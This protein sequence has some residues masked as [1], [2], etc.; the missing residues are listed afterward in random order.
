LV[1]RIV[2]AYDSYESITDNENSVP[3]SPQS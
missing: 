2:E 3:R 1:Q